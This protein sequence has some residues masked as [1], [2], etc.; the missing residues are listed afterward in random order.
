MYIQIFNWNYLLVVVFLLIVNVRL[1]SKLSVLPGFDKMRKWVITILILC[2]CYSLAD[3]WGFFLGI[4]M[5]IQQLY[6][7]NA[8]TDLIFALASFL[9]FFYSERKV[10]SRIFQKW[11]GRILMALPMV[12]MVIL[13]I[14]SWKTG[15]VFYI[16]EYGEYTYGP[17]F[18]IYYFGLENGYAELALIHSIYRL[19]S[20]HRSNYRRHNLNTIGYVSCILSGTYLQLFFRD[21]PCANMGMTLAIIL[22]FVDCQENL[23]NSS[24]EQLQDAL[25]EMVVS[26]EIINAISKIYTLIYRIDLSRNFMEEVSNE[27]EIHRLSGNVD[28]ATEILE[29]GI[30]RLVDADSR[31]AMNEFLDLSTLQERMQTEENIRME[32]RGTDGNWYSNWKSI[33]FAPDCTEYYEQCH[34]I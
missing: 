31:E 29:D 34:Q 26:N 28:K 30:L 5:K 24:R 23:L 16:T 4:T 1:A 25:Q 22:I 14:V 2:V 12:G 3:V 18:V 10:C 13:Q 20:D 17:L 32:Y 9:I 15:N 27:D 11:S 19:Y 8:I 21:A 6:G 33:T 7:I